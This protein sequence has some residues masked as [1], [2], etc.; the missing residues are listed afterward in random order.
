MK[1]FGRHSDQDPSPR[2]L[3]ACWT[4]WITPCSR[5][6]SGTDFPRPP[7]A[8]SSAAA[9]VARP[10]WRCRYPAGSA[11]GV[12]ARDELVEHALGVL[13]GH[14]AGA[15]RLVAAA[16]VGQHQL[17][18]AG[19]RRAVEDRLAGREHGVLLLEAPED[20]DRD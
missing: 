18:D 20:V 16:A 17:A 11:V 13:V 15:R 6:P 10:S 14:L 12:D 5:G 2:R 4:R 3:P 8:G 9:A 7:E 1:G 19:A